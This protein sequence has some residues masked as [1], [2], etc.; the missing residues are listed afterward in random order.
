MCVF[1]PNILIKGISLGF[2]K[3]KI[4]IVTVRVEVSLGLS[5]S[6]VGGEALCLGGVLP[7]IPP[8]R[9]NSCGVSAPSSETEVS[10]LERSALLGL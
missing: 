9:P 4:W 10:E 6:G 3:T 1:P 7:R 5:L 2:D 8:R